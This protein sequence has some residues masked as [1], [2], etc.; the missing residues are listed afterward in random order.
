MERNTLVVLLA[1]IHERKIM[2]MT[3]KWIQKVEKLSKIAKSEPQAAYTA[4]IIG[5][6]HRFTY[7]LRTMPYLKNM[8]QP[9]DDIIAKKVIPAISDGRICS[10][11]ERRLLSLP[12]KCGGLGYQFS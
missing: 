12:P 9:L 6:K 11:I 8:L 5:Q 7:N 2:V 4:F 1:K 3:S 10:S